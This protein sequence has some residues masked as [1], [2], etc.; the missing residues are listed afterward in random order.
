MGSDGRILSQGPISDVIKLDQ[1]LANI[2]KADED[3]TKLSE[4]LEDGNDVIKPT[5]NGKLIVAEE[6]DVG[7][8]SWSPS[9]CQ[10]VPTMHIYRPHIAP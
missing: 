4:K 10:L 3:L 7:H 2:L 5:S 1:D 6:V 9:E 8:V